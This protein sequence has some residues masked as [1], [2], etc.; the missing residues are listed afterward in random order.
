MTPYMRCE[1]WNRLHPA[2][3]AQPSVTS[4]LALYIHPNY[5]HLDLINAKLK[6][7]VLATCDS[8]LNYLKKNGS[9]G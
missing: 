2:L 1:S 8:T 4:P 3:D 6:M 9:N 7:T 5:C